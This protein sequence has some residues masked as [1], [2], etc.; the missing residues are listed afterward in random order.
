MLATAPIIVFVVVLGVLVAMTTF[1]VSRIE[2][3]HP[4]AGQFIEVEGVRLHM[5]EL[6]LRRGSPG[7]EPAVVL[8]HGASG[9]ME[10]MRLALGEKLAASIA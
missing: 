9:N 5:A 4:P 10:D 6:G 7:A 1:G 3:A 8:I 2:A